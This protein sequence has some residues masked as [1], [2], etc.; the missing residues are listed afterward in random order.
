M[1]LLSYSLGMI[2]INQFYYSVFLIMSTTR[3]IENKMCERFIGV[4]EFG[5]SPSSIYLLVK[6]LVLLYR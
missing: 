1:V 5:K 2:L 3:Y 6:Q 4:T